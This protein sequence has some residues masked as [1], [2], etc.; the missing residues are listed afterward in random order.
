MRGTSRVL[1]VTNDP[2]RRSWLAAANRA[3]SDFPIQNLPI[4]VFRP[5]GT[6]DAFRGGI[7]IGNQIVDLAALAA[8]GTLSGDAGVAALAAA[9]PTLN[10][11]MTLGPRYWKALRDWLAEGLLDGSALQATLETCLVPQ[12]DVEYALP[13]TI[14]DY[15]DFYS[16]I[17]HATAVGRL[18]RP[19]NPL[20]PNYRWV[21]VGYHGRSSSIMISGTPF[22][23]PC[24]QTL[25]GGAAPIV[26][27]T[28]RLDYE[29]ELGI[30]IGKGNVPGS[31]VP[32]A[33][34]ES[35]IFGVCLLND[36]SARD[37]Q[38]WEYQP[39]G[40]FLAKN[41]ATSISPWIVSLQALAP[42]RRAFVRND[43]DPAP[44]PY[45][46]SEWNRT[47]GAFDIELEA[48][49][50]TRSMRA[51]GEP[52]QQLSST[53]F[54]HSYWTLAQLV[55]H[56]TVNGCNLRAGDLL[57]TGTQSGPQ[58]GEAG[59]L[60]ELTAGGT[61]PID[62]GADETRTFLLDDDEIR[63]SGWCAGP[64]SARIGFGEVS[65]RAILA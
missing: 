31:S 64:G 55:A 50:Q 40:P 13:A 6:V 15:T 60:L 28:E 22:R 25:Q 27:S 35:H 3:G 19:D 42:Y 49:L 32:I 14:G 20:L 7:A 44:L 53:S 54:R 12:A 5:R 51:R 38:A 62:I 41:F 47:A 34:A 21:P 39:L 48:F 29:V 9:N 4:A 57:G 56:H 18:F 33:D 58:P 30:F 52:A 37:L 2:A 17:Y 45:L 1:D 8:S 61:R 23:R 63:I 16:S 10:E 43:Q 59:S 26:R 11:L 46:D 24:G 36:W 65:G